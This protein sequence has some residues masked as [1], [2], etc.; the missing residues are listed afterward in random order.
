MDSYGPDTDVRTIVYVILN[1]GDNLHEYIEDYLEQL[2]SFLVVT[3]LP[4][5]EIVFDVKPK[6]YS[7]ASDSPAS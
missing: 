3:P 6:F 2:R 4:K 1:F 5:I 7:A